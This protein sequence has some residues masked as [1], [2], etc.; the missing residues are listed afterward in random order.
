[1]IGRTW[2]GSV[3]CLLV[4]ACGG[5][6]AGQLVVLGDS[7]SDAYSMPREAGWVAVLDRR[8]GPGHELVDGSISGDTTAGALARLPDLLD[9]TRPDAVLVI[10]GG[11]DGLRGLDARQL[12]DNLAAIVDRARAA[13]AKV[14][15]MQVRLPPNLGPRYVREFEAVY[16]EVA[17]RTGATLIPFM[18]EPLVGREGMFLPDGIH[19]TRAAQTE[20]A[21]FMQPHVEAL[22]EDAD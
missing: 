16:P 18:L 15:L 4:V 10:L 3:A 8:L 19:P 11:N 12:R 7:L 14:A 17:A 21:D 22:L 13:G 2:I 5:V 20:I 6:Q 1:M 9:A